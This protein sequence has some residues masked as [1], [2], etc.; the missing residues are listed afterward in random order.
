MVVTDR[1][2]SKII[3]SADIVQAAHNAA[4]INQ[5]QISLVVPTSASK[6]FGIALVATGLPPLP[7]PRVLFL[8][9]IDSLLSLGFKSVAPA[10]L[11]SG[12]E[13]H[14]NRRPTLG[15]PFAKSTF[16]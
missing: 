13:G 1:P 8:D 3:K 16:E 7:T 5:L 10:P 15:I 14:K 4:K 2:R 9:S 12:G 6:P 11:P